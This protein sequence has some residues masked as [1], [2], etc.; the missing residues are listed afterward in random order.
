MA[1][2]RHPKKEIEAV[3]KYA[4]SLG[5]RWQKATNHAWG[6]LLC[7]EASR[8]GCAISVNST[9]KNAQNHAKKIKKSVDDCP[10]KISKPKATAK[11]PSPGEKP[12]DKGKKRR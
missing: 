5:W 3:V 1:R 6:R 7:I 2:P 8:D 11:K 10:H 9:P 4:E 12:D